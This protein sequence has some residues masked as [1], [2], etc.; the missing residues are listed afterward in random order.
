MLKIYSGSI[1]LSIA[2]LIPAAHADELGDAAQALCEKVKSCAMA[3]IEGQNIPAETREMMQPMLDGMCTQIRG[4]VGEVP[5][6]HPLYKPAVACMESMNSL[7]CENM[8]EAGDMIT[9]ECE[10]YEELARDAGV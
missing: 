10:E 8:Q 7:S 2:I 9:P 5:T 6:G 3:Q 1:L 4:K